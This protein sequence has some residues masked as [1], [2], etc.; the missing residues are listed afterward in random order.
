MWTL[1]ADDD[2]AAGGDADGHDVAGQETGFD[3]PDATQADVGNLA[4]QVCLVD[5]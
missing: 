1:G 2:E 4:W 5:G 3:Q